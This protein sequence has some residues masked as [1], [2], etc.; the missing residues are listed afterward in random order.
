MLKFLILHPYVLNGIYSIIFL[1]CSIR[2]NSI[3]ELIAWLTIYTSLYYNYQ[4]LGYFARNYYQ[5]T[6]MGHFLISPTLRIITF[7]SLCIFIIIGYYKI[8]PQLT[9]NFLK[10]LLNSKIVLFSLAILC[11]TFFAT[12][13][14]IRQKH[15]D[16]EILKETLTPFIMLAFSFIFFIL[17][18]ADQHLKKEQLKRIFLIVSIFIIFILCIHLTQFIIGRSRF[19]Y[20]SDINHISL[21]EGLMYNPLFMANW[22]IFPLLMYI[23]FFIKKFH[24]ILS[25]MLFL[26]ICVAIYFAGSRIILYSLLTLLPLGI[27]LAFIDKRYFSLTRCSAGIFLLTT[28]LIMIPLITHSKKQPSPDQARTLT[29]Q[30]FKLSYRYYQG[31]PEI[32]TLLGISDNITTPVI[33]LFYSK[34]Y[35]DT[36]VPIKSPNHKSFAIVSWQNHELKSRRSTTTNV[37]NMYIIT[38]YKSGIAALI[39]WIIFIASIP[40]CSLYKIITCEQYR[41]EGAIIFLFGFFMTYAIAFNAVFQIIV[42]WPLYSLYFALYF[43]YM[44]SKP[45]PETPLKIPS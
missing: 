25:S 37:D 27:L 44:T 38:R 5:Y 4:F 1:Y 23:Y 16:L 19:Y 28:T 21:A 17:L 33:K 35:Y 42:L 8:K 9:Y 40:L 36:F 24:R 11:L 31:M 30:I 43:L 32:M 14:Y 29:A 34:F 41:L 15:F 20:S 2:S 22:Y 18:K 10:K 26:I 3:L 7:G 6:N 13:L 12:A 39:F 45:K